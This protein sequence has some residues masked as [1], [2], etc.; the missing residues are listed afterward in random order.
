MIKEA[1][2]HLLH[3]GKTQERKI[4]EHKGMSYLLSD[5][6]LER[7]KVPTLNETIH[8]NT[9]SGILI[10]VNKQ[11]DGEYMQ[12]DKELIV[13]I[14]SPEYVRVESQIIDYDRHLYLESKPIL[15]KIQF[16]T[17]YDIE[18]FVIKLQA[19]F[20][21]TEDLG[22]ILAVVGN[23][24]EEN[25]K[26]VGDNGITQGVTIKQGVSMSKDTIVPN[27]VNLKP[28][29]TFIEVDQPESAFV[30]RLQDGPRAALFE[31][32]GGAWRIEA[33]ENIRKYLV[34][35]LDTELATVLV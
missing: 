6:G 7:I 24:K 17:W 26:T 23:I 29:R 14:Q 2:E 20:E 18:E 3:V 10:Y 21:P 33:M 15:P 9:L 30:F 12:N 31:A 32:D 25:V 11:I 34:E 27:P 1:I 19:C 16:G 8:I 13:N 28:Y 5:R 35:N 4:I 22:K